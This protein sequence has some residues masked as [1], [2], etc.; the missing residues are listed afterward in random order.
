YDPWRWPLSPYVWLST[1]RPSMS[2]VLALILKPVYVQHGLILRRPHRVCLQ[3]CQ[4]FFH[5][6]FADIAGAELIDKQADFTCQ[7]GLVQGLRQPWPT[8]RSAE[9]GL[10]SAHLI[11]DI[12]HGCF[13]IQVHLQYFSPAFGHR[14]YPLLT[15]VVLRL[16]HREKQLPPATPH[17]HKM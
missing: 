15:L 17:H 10:S 5:A 1:V 6:D 8:L 7:G 9:R 16:W 3:Q 2:P 13:F 14:D 12:Q 11:A 4:P